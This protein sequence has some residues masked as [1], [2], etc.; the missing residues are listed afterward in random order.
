MTGNPILINSLRFII[1]LFLQLLVLKQI[2]IGPIGPYFIGIQ[3]YPLFIL[4]LPFRTSRELIL[5]L[6]FA[7]GLAVDLFYD[8]PG[9]HAGAAV[10]TAFV[11]PA[12]LRRLE[13]RG[14]YTVTYS[15]TMRRYSFAWFWRYAAFMLV[16][17]LLFYFSLEVFTPVFWIEILVK[18][19]LT[20]LVSLIFVLILMLIFNPLD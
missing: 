5:L 9:V 6:A 3:V 16:F 19:L 20:T 10:F 15:P 2:S 14:G 13:P 1:L 17:H 11:R 7:M 12:V 8:S 18:T 4:L